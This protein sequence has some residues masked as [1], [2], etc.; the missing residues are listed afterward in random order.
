MACARGDLEGDR[1][2]VHLVERAVEQRHL[3]VDHR[4]ADQHAVV[5]DRL[6]AL[7][8][9]G[10]VFLRHRAAD[11]RRLSNSLPLPV[12]FGSSAQLDARELARTTGL[13][14]VRVVDLGRPRRASRD[15]RPAARRR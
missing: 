7:F 8:D 1:R 10:N 15:R 4:E 6:D 13:L 2:R 5:P 9:A 12:S 14:L 3:D 11:D